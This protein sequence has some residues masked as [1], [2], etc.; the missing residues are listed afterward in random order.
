MVRLDDS[1]GNSTAD[2]ASVDGD[3]TYTCPAYLL[4]ESLIDFSTHTVVEAS[5][6]KSIIQTA[7]L[8]VVRSVL[9]LLIHMF[10][11]AIS[12]TSKTPVSIIA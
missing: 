11:K 8:I 5:T 12:S 7:I 9:V 3:F 6:I 10:L 4:I 1:G 2:A